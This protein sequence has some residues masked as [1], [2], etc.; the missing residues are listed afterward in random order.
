MRK[1]FLTLVGLVV[2][3][4]LFSCAIR[5]S[6]KN[7]SVNLY[8]NLSQLKQVQKF[9]FKPTGY[10]AEIDKIYV[11]VKNSS[12]ET[13]YSTETANKENPS[14]A[15]VLPRIGIYN[16]Y[17][18]AK[19]SDGSRIFTGSREGYQITFGN[20]YVSIDPVLVNGTLRVNIE[21]DRLIWEKY[22]V[23]TAAVEFKKVIDSEWMSRTPTISD[24]KTVL[25]ETLYPFMY[26][27]RFKV[28][29]NA[30]EESTLPG[31]WDNLNNP[32]T[33]SVPVD[34][35][36]VRNVTF[37]VV[38]NHEEQRPEVSIS[39]SEITMPYLMEVNNLMALW[40]PIDSQ[41]NVFWNY[42]DE[43]AM[44]Y[45]YKE[46]KDQGNN[47]VYELVGSTTDK[48]YVIDNF[49]ENEYNRVTGIAIDV[50]SD[51]KSSGL[52]V[53]PKENFLMLQTA[54]LPGAPNFP[55]VLSAQYE[56]Y[57]QKL[58]LTWSAVSGNV[59]YRVYRK[60]IGEDSYTLLK[61]KIIGTTV[62]LDFPLSEFENIDSIAISAY[63]EFG[64]SEK[65]E[66]EKSSIE[67]LDFAGGS[68]T[69]SDPYLIGNA[70]QLQNVNKSKY[71]NAGKY[72]KLIDDIDLQGIE[73]TPIG[74]FRSPYSENAFV[75]TFDGNGKKILNL[76]YND[77]SKS[78]VGLF[79]CVYNSK[80]KNLIIENATITALAY[81]G[82]L[83]GYCINSVVEKVGVR[84]SSMTSHGQVSS[85]S[86]GG[87]I[88]KVFADN[89][90]THPMEIRQCFADNVTV[91]APKYD[92]QVYLGGLIGIVHV[93]KQTVIEDCY[94]TGVVKFKSSSSTAVG[95]LIGNNPGDTSGELTILR[96]YAAVA[97]GLKDNLQWRGFIGEQVSTSTV[98]GKNYF[99]KDVAGTSVG[100]AKS[101]L[102]EAKTTIE[103]KQRATFVD[104]DFENTWIIEEG[105]DYPRL[106]WEY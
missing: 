38:F 6:T 14:I 50:I 46:I 91:S 60:L 43:K 1:V 100:S 33:L 67:L 65:R 16:F 2:L 94:A 63:N 34:P 83:A 19:R 28:K 42:T 72:F 25:E 103:M 24:T 87:L 96:C 54:G 90:S 55:E 39:I 105:N 53:L 76:T 73:W 58:T 80:I 4:V 56:D 106:R 61:S 20:N 102:Q 31:T 15:F 9:E 93:K 35:D 66:L 47:V 101:S 32:N 5:P 40:D 18:E 49:D 7:I 81:I 79:G 57:S 71:L 82:A 41:L 8:V 75:G 84:N 30:K 10:A 23:E 59:K 37:K 89:S 98:S 44:F 29:L 97:P 86:T 104:W 78:H 52:A 26:T 95:G 45:I 48:R 27:V 85:L 69:E 88:G 36:R 17:I 12:G 68:G 51:N 74:V 62:T 13:V 70:R 64:E 3:F 21:I 92:S 11:T 77:A 99:D 22:N